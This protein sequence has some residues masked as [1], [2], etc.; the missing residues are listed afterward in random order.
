[1]SWSLKGSATERKTADC[2]TF[3][4]VWRIP[5]VGVFE[6]LWGVTRAAQPSRLYLT[7]FGIFPFVQQTC[8]WH[9]RVSASAAPVYKA[10]KYRRFP[11]R[12][13]R[14]SHQSP[15]FGDSYSEIWHFVEDRK[16]F[17]FRSRNTPS[18]CVVSRWKLKVSFWRWSII[19]I[20]KPS[21]NLNTYKQT[22][23]TSTV[24]MDYFR[25][26]K[27]KHVENVYCQ[28]NLCVQWPQ[29]KTGDCTM[30]MYQ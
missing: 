15:T 5:S 9:P 30:Y 2:C 14:S 6:S 18:R 13:I 8:G 28:L 1:M 23:K 19:H 20:A 29:I 3:I 11:V 27:K 12:R 21:I 16:T 26:K 10:L 25:M 7:L 22:E 4:S 17:F 24:G